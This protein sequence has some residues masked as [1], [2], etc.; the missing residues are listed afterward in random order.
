MS[1]KNKHSIH[2]PLIL[3]PLLVL[4]LLT[5]STSYGAVKWEYKCV[6][7]NREDAGYRYTTYLENKF[8]A[9]GEKGWEMVGYAMNNGTNVRY[10]C[11]KREK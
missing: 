8:N 10:V 9:L 3:Y 6:D 5:T 1:R 4:T 11:F 7:T 2:N